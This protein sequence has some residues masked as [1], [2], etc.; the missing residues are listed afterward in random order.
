M[1]V[2]LLPELGRVWCGWHTRGANRRSYRCAAH[3]HNAQQALHFLL[4][5]RLA[6]AAALRRRD[7]EQ[8]APEL[9]GG[10]G[11]HDGDRALLRHAEAAREAADK[12]ARGHARHGAPAARRSE[13]VLDGVAEDGVA[14]GVRGDGGCDVDV[15]LLDTRAWGGVTALRRERMR[16]RKCS[17]RP[18]A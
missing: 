2:R 4:H 5:A 3:L 13:A 11:V 7:G 16:R 6:A 1:L 10:G 8:H 17:V 15:A 18:A 14:A 9:R 12:L